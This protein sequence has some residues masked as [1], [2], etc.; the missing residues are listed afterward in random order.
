MTLPTQ[1][2]ITSTGPKPNG[3]TTGEKQ[4]AFEVSIWNEQSYHGVQLLEVLD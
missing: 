3:E 1:S 4:S 2:K